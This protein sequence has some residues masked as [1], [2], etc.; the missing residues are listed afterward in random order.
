MR[1]RPS[2]LSVASA[3][4]ATA[5]TVFVT[6]AA[7]GAGNTSNRSANPLTV[8]ATREVAMC[9][10]RLKEAVLLSGRCHGDRS[11]CQIG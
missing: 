10:D 5:I 4:A 6:P 2:K 11:Q 1:L 3:G 9:S 7:A 8:H